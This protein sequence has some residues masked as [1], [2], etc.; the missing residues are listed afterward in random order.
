M[1]WPK[2]WLPMEPGFKEARIM[3]FGY[4]AF[5]KSGGKDVFN[6]SDFAKDLL[7]QMKFANSEGGESLNIG[8]APIIFVCH[9]MGGLVAKKVSQVPV[10]AFRKSVLE[11]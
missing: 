6:I 4:N 1:F 7:L 10:E 8:K 11:N 9:S 2:A 5:F 3:T